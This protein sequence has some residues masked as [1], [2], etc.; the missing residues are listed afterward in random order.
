MKRF[1][2]GDVVLCVDDNWARPMLPGIT[3]PVKGNIYTVRKDLYECVLLEEIKNDNYSDINGNLV[4]DPR[5]FEPKWYTWHFE[6]IEESE[7]AALVTTATT[8][9]TEASET[10]VSIPEYI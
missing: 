6:K 7:V 8:I 5:G 10:D 4:L 1:K 9:I 3:A 2:K